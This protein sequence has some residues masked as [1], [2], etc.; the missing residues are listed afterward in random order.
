MFQLFVMPFTSVVKIAK[1]VAL[2][3]ISS[4]RSSLLG[5]DGWDP[6]ATCVALYVL[7]NCGKKRPVITRD[8]DAARYQRRTGLFITY[9][10]GEGS[11][12]PPPSIEG[13]PVDGSAGL[14]QRPFDVSREAFG[15]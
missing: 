12:P 10:A 3:M 4:K 2:S 13:I 11:P 9:S 8:K 6:F 1:S 5:A 15:A 7:T 14:A